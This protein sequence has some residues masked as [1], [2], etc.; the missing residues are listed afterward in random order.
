VPTAALDRAH[1]DYVAWRVEALG[2]TSERLPGGGVIARSDRHP[3]HWYANRIVA[4]TPGDAEI[5]AGAGAGLRGDGLPVRVELPQPL[6]NARL[7]DGLV[8]AGFA[9]DWN[10]RVLASPIL[11][12]PSPA[13]A[14]IQL[15]RVNSASGAER[16][17]QGYEACFR[18]RQPERRAHVRSLAARPGGITAYIVASEG[19]VVGVA[20]MYQ[21]EEVALLADAATHPDWRGRGIHTLLVAARLADAKEAAARIVTSDVEP[22]GGSDRNLARLGLRGGYL[23]EVWTPREAGDGRDVVATGPGGPVP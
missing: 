15:E 3:D 18:E 8:K 12:V 22:G 4:A 10:S 21:V 20:L 13:I 6:L 14:G 9:Q 23:R 5:A 7:R 19:D 2:G 11:V 1:A 16:F 17:W